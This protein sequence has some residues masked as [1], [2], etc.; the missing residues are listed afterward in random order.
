MAFGS[1]SNGLVGLKLCI[2]ASGDVK[3]ESNPDFEERGYVSTPTKNRT[4]D[5]RAQVNVRVF[6]LSIATP[7]TLNIVGVTDS[8]YVNERSLTFNSG[9]FDFAIRKVRRRSSSPSWT[10]SVANSHSQLEVDGCLYA[11]LFPASL[12]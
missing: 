2:K 5:S 9:S 12:S 4:A 1:G 7:N 11:R 10:A 8:E 3:D 6:E